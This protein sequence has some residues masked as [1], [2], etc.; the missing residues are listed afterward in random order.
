MKILI[1]GANG[2]LGTYCSYFFEQAGYRVTPISR[3]QDPKIRIEDFELFIARGDYDFVVNAV[4]LSGHEQCEANPLQAKKINALFPEV[5]ARAAS[6]VGC[7]FVQISTD[8]VFDGM[9]SSPYGEFDR[10]N[11]TSQ[12]GLSKLEGEL[13]V[14]QVN[15]S[16]IVIRTNFFGWSKHGDK[17]I[18]DFFVKSFTSDKSIL[19]F[20]DYIVSSIYMGDLLDSIVFL[21]K[22]DA[23]GLFHVS[24]STPLSKFEFGELVGTSLN[25]SFASME[26]SSIDRAQGLVKRGSNLSLSNSKIE[27]L[28]GASQPSTLEGIARAVSEHSSIRMYFGN[29]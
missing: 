1:L 8:A 11:P 9:S 2:F 18:L 29:R 27:K 17:G 7:K 23:S 12:Y 28:T 26:R 15:S 14:L 6:S 25:L 10:T 3:Q 20:D 24:S 19:G 4:A 5:W 13:R 22:N 16:S 21:V